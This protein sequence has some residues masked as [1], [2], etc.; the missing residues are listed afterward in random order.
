MK[1]VTVAVVI[2]SLLVCAFGFAAQLQ[3]G[4]IKNRIYDPVRGDGFAVADIPVLVTRL[5]WFRAA[6]IPAFLVLCLAVHRLLR[7]PGK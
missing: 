7:K 5:N 6:T 2:A 1:V 3:L 4:A